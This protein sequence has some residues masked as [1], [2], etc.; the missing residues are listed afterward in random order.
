MLRSSYVINKEMMQDTQKV[1]FDF[2]T[3]CVAKFKDQNITETLPLWFTFSFPVETSTIN[4]GNSVFDGPSALMPLKLRVKILSNYLK[5]HST[6]WFNLH[7]FCG[8]L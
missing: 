1:L 5:R 8:D 3:D 7:K 4:S 2:V 6:E